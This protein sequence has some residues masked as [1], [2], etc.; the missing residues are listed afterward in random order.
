MSFE[1]QWKL[2]TAS[3]WKVK[4]VVYTSGIWINFCDSV[5]TCGAYQWRVRAKCNDSTYS[6]WA[7]GNKFTVICGIRKVTLHQ[8]LTITPN[9]ASSSIAVTAGGAKRGLVKLRVFNFFGRAIAERM[10]YVRPDGTVS[11]K[12]ALPPGNRG[13][14]FVTLILDG[15]VVNRGSFLKE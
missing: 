1:V 2:L 15:V 9:P 11:E 6:E 10:V 12:F 14:Y 3:V 4:T 8:P 7:T 13:V 5:D